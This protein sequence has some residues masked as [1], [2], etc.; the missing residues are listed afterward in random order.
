MSV[1]KQFSVLTRQPFCLPL[2]GPE[3][4]CGIKHLRGLIGGGSG[5]GGLTVNNKC[6]T[7]Q[8]DFFMLSRIHH[9]W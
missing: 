4:I 7:W 6:F 9:V 5:E 1:E 8:I 3:S 2:G